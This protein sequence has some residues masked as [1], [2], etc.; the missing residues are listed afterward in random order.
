M[1]LVTATMVLDLNWSHS[2]LSAA[3]S[4]R[5]NNPGFTGETET[6][7]RILL[8]AILALVGCS[9]AEM[10]ED[11]D[12]RIPAEWSDLAAANESVAQ[13]AQA[14]S[15]GPTGG[16]RHTLTNPI[17]QFTDPVGQSW[18]PNAWYASTDPFTWRVGQ[19]SAP[20]SVPQGQ[21]IT[22][23]REQVG[24]LYFQQFTCPNGQNYSAMMQATSSEGSNYMWSKATVRIT[25]T[26]VATGCRRQ[27]LGKFNF[28][29][30]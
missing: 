22:T 30:F 12:S 26:E 20:P 8:F 11:A 19:Y 2:W 15:C 23:Y 3:P 24:C 21:C 7:M 4:G 1:Q 18:C 25:A 16:Y 14:L 28:T 17:M 10:T 13:A 9:S 27:V 29:A 6:H 5:N